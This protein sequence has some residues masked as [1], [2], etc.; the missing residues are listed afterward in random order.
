M[1]HK[2]NIVFL[3]YSRYVIMIAYFIKKIFYKNDICTLIVSDAI[4][5]ENGLIEHIREC[6]IW[7]KTITLPEKNR[8]VQ[9]I[10]SWVDHYL[11]ENRVDI[12]FVAHIRRCASHY[13]VKKLGDGTEINMF[14]EG[15]ITLD[16]EEGYER[17]CKKGLPCG[18]VEFEFDKVA[19]MYVLFPEIT[20]AVG[21][22]KLVKINLP[23]S[24]QENLKQ[25]VMD[26]NHLFAYTYKK[27]QKPIILIDADIAVQG[28]VAQEYENHCIK[29]ILSYIKEENCIVKI[30]PAESKMLLDSKYGATQVEYLDNGLVPFEV[31]YMNCILH[32][33]LP[34]C[35][36][37]L[38]TTLIWNMNLI[39]QSLNLLTTKI[40]SVAKI[41][42]AFYL[43]EHERSAM[44]DKIKKY[45]SCFNSEYRICMPNSWVEFANIFIQNKSADLVLTRENGW[46]SNAYIDLQIE[47]MEKENAEKKKARIFYEWMQ[48]MQKNIVISEY[49][50]RNNIPR[51]IMYGIGQFGKLLIEDLRTVDIEIESI[52]VTDRVDKDYQGIDIETP[53]TKESKKDYPIVVTSVGYEEEICVKLVEQGVKNRIIKMEDILT[54]MQGVR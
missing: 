37:A 48:L 36:V 19:N 43:Q 29:N 53:D 5:N 39:N 30:K 44:L 1:T 41:M 47:H 9:E 54:Y 23:I 10:Y 50:I 33:E 34:E 18:W 28:F 17:V 26:L 20:K 40:V 25:M 45:Q 49:F 38:P 2:K 13:F 3:C 6:E 32:N 15:I 51:I 35:V 21:T 31:V 24:N 7:D 11:H 14:D 52:W 12:F 22:S 4:G 46:L 27:I 8:S 42:G 16:I